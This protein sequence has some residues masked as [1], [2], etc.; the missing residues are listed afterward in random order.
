MTTN[1]FMQL[2]L[3]KA[4]ILEEEIKMNKK[5]F[6]KII[7]ILLAIIV[8]VSTI[9]ITRTTTPVYA[10][11]KPIKILFVGNSMTSTVTSI[12][13]NLKEMI[14][15]TGDKAEI[16]KFICFGKGFKEYADKKN[17]YGKQLRKK[18][19]KKKYDYII[20]QEQPSAMVTAFEK[21]TYPC[22]KTLKKLAVKNGAK[23]ILFM[24]WRFNYNFEKKTKQKKY[25]YTPKQMLK[26]L[27]KNSLKLSADYNVK[28]VTVGL[29]FE[30]SNK[31][32]PNIFLW[33]PKEN[34][35]QGKNG[36]YLASCIFYRELFGKSATNIKF[37]AKLLVED[38]LKLQKVSDVVM[39]LNKSKVKL[40]RGKKVNL[41]ASIKSLGVNNSYLPQK[42]SYTYQSAD[43][44]IATVNSR[45]QVKAKKKGKTLI[46][47]TSKR[48]GLKKAC[49]V[50]VK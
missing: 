27:S 10:Q 15:T 48:T 41:T 38:A 12:P 6:Q 1:T 35:H 31:I 40:K 34:K 39:S 25:K 17:K 21:E 29:Y 46:Y 5:I 45:G 28:V 20:F 43:K 23:P 3:Y 13:R 7:C 33:R 26:I 24:T 16:D 30:Y 8:S 50:V 18:L 22:F 37:Y 14:K 42:D 36:A 9:S 49:S 11:S 47:I 32:L 44:K 2:R 19:K 4:F